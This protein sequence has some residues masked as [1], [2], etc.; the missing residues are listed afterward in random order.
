MS[1]IGGLIAA[2]VSFMANKISL[3]TM[4]EAGIIVIVPAIE[5]ISKTLTALILKANIIGCHFAFGFIEGIYDIINSSS[6]IGKWAA[7]ASIISHTGFG[8]V[9]YLLIRAGYPTYIGIFL[10]WLLHSSWNWY[11]IKYF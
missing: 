5:E 2:L 10:S 8:T 7:L 3:K 9:A 1:I 4:G 11:V 6:R